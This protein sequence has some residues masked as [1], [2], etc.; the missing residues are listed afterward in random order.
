MTSGGCVSHG[1]G[2]IALHDPFNV[3][4]ATI[5]PASA[6]EPLTI[7]WSYENGAPARQSITGDFG[8]VSLAPGIR[9]YT[10][11]PQNSGSR[12][13][14]IDAS[15]DSPAT[16]PPV[17]SR[18]RSVAKSP[19]A[20]SGC[21]V[22][23]AVQQ[24]TVGICSPPAVIVEGPS[25]VV[26]GS[27]FQLSVRPQPGAITTWLITNGSPA[28]ATG[29]SVMITAGS[30]G[31]VGVDVRLTRGACV[32]QLDRSIAIDAK[33]VC[34]NPKV[35]VSA[36][37]VGCGS[38]IVNAVFTG[39]PP[40]QGTWSDGAPFKTDA[41]TLPRTITLP[42]TYRIVSFE[43][44]ACAG[45]SSGVAEV[46]AVSP[47]ATIIGKVN[48]CIG[49]DKVTV[50][51]TGK[52]P[53]TGLWLDGTP[54]DTKEM[55]IVKPVTATGLNSLAYAYDGTDCRLSV[56]GSV[57]GIQPMTLRAERFCLSPDFDNVV[58]VY[59]TLVD[60]SFTN[61][62]T[63]TWSDGVTN[64]ADGYPNYRVGVKPDKTT[65]YTIVSGHDANC[66]AIIG[67]PASVTVYASPIPDFLLGIGELCTGVTKS[68]SLATPPPA[69]ATVHWFVDGGTLVSGQGT[70]AIQYKSEVE[71][72][73]TVGCTFN[74][75]DDR[76]PTSTR[77][78]VRIDGDPIGTL[79]L[80][81]SEAHPGE[82]ILITYTMNTATLSANLYD[83]HDQYI[84]FQGICGAHINCQAQYST[85]QLG[86][87][88]IRLEMEGFCANKKTISVPLMIVP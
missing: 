49:T 33:A 79:S 41:M 83:S 60:S 42:G 48:S 68:A 88:T 21:A 1:N 27:T 24:Y 74:F 10:Y 6:S 73:T 66:P 37:P 4:F 45:A 36:G 22:V 11:T 67:S 47:S 54:L 51:F 65:T 56:L 38:A 44:A 58:L 64:T 52:P 19:V 61:P 23:H 29:D 50:Q 78:A 69:D 70:S 82:N 43:D 14:V 63:V 84:P 80:S 5:P 75:P 76:C 17:T 62:I 71:G 31:S 18:Q 25:S 77:R 55:Q 81:K 7:S 30:S 57:Q 3:R 53:F 16:P 9:S 59:A 34:N 13:V 28:V 12:Q 8:T 72:T 46:P 15:M 32:G 26:I 20:A 40:F 86:L 35:V 2:V 87:T 39:T 85:T